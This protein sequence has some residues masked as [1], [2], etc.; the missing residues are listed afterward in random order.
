MRHVHV[1]VVVVSQWLLVI[2][3][4]MGLESET[5][6]NVRVLVSCSSIRTFK[7]ARACLAAT[8]ELSSLKTKLRKYMERKSPHPSSAERL[9]RKPTFKSTERKPNCAEIK[10]RTAIP[11]LG[12]ER[13]DGTHK[14]HEHTESS[15][16]EHY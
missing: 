16:N 3:F 1:R 10:R 12:Y 13:S 5:S 15:L 14:Q 7:F 2:R 6:I 4:Q 9:L 11:N 8:K